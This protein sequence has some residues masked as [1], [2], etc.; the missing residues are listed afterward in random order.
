MCLSNALNTIFHQ[1][2]SGKQLEPSICCPRERR[3]GVLE[4]IAI[5][6]QLR[7]QHGQEF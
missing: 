6:E 1:H 7:G 5:A 4:E 3:H 2:I